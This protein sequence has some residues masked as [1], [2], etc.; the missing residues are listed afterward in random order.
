MESIQTFC[1]LLLGVAREIIV[2]MGGTK[3]IVLGL[4]IGGLDI[5]QYFNT[6]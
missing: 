6:A 5:F 1:C 2:H 3:P 4:D